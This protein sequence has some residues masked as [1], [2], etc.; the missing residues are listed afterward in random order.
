MPEMLPLKWGLVPHWATD[1]KV[2]Y[3]MINVRSE[4]AA[5]KPAFRDSM[6]SRRC[7]VATDE[8]YEWQV[9]PGGKIPTFIQRVGAG[10][11]IVPFFFA[12]AMGQLA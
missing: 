1:V 8:R 3:K 6:K 4:T 11:E 10:G 2:G 12:G 7:L 5:T 9:T